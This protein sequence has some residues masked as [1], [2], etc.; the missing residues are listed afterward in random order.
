MRDSPAM[1]LSAL[2]LA[3]LLVVASPAL[4]QPTTTVAGASLRFSGKVADKNA[5]NT[6]RGELKNG[7]TGDAV[8]VVETPSG[9]VSIDNTRLAVA[10]ALGLSRVP[11][12][13]HGLND[14]LPASWA[15]WRFGP[16]A[17][18]WGEALLHRCTTSGLSPFGTAERP[19]VP[20]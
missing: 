6:L 3:A 4:A 12:R 18:T 20:G 11:V 16:E 19:K 17:K 8:D 2:L 13:V 14:P 9:L 1:R 15:G 7:W 5:A 10:Q